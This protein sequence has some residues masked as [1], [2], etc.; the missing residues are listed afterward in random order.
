MLQRILPCNSGHKFMKREDFKT[1]AASLRDK[2]AKFKLKKV[3]LA[4]CVWSLWMFVDSM[5]L[6]PFD[7]LSSASLDTK[8]QCALV[9]GK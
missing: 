4:L 3:G 9:K 1:Y 8:W 7:R 2:S 6:P 5:P